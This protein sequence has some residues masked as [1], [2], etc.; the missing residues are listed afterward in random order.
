MTRVPSSGRLRWALDGI[1]RFVGGSRARAAQLRDAFHV[2]FS[3]TYSELYATYSVRQQCMLT[4]YDAT[5]THFGIQILA[6]TLGGSARARVEV[7]TFEDMFLCYLTTKSSSK[8]KAPCVHTQCP[9]SLLLEISVHPKNLSTNC[10]MD[11]VV[12]DGPSHSPPPRPDEPLDVIDA[13]M[14]ASSEFV[15]SDSSDDPTF[16][17]F[18][19]DLLSEED[20]SVFRD[21]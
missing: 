9:I 17:S 14:D 2:A 8:F 21:H 7:V 20:P 18:L 10:E 19:K 16:F 1:D 5:Q 15:G 3:S 4:V 12:E 11:R 13:P 6:V